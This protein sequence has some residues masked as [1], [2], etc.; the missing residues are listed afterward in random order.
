MLLI[1]PGLAMGGENLFR[2]NV[3]INMLL[4]FAVEVRIRMQPTVREITTNYA[5]AEAAGVPDYLTT[6]W[7]LYHAEFGWPHRQTNPWL[8]AK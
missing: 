2:T 8:T 6:F 5:R 7:L 3:G 4:G 1:S